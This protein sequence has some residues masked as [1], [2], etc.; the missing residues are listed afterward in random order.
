VVVTVASVSPHKVRFCAA[1]KR[2]G[3][4]KPAKGCRKC[5]VLAWRV[6]WRNPE[7]KTRSEVFDGAKMANPHD[8]A[9]AKKAELEKALRDG[10]YVDP[11][12]PRMLFVDFADMWAE[13][14]DWKDTTRDFWPSMRKRYERF[15]GKTATLGSIDR[16]RLLAIRKSL[17][18]VYASNTVASTMYQL[19]AILREAAATGRIPRDPTVNVK[20]TPKRR[21]DDKT[22]RV[23]PDK[24]PTADE[25]WSM[26][27]AAPIEWQ[28][29]HALGLAAL[30]IGEVL[31]MER[32]RV[33]L[34]TGEIMV[35][36]QASPT[37]GKGIVLTTP[38]AE[39][40]RT[41]IAPDRVLE[42]VAAHIAAGYGGA[43][44]D[45]DGVEHEMLFLRNG[46]LVRHEAFYKFGY[47]PALQAAG[48][49]GRF[50]F[51]GYRHHVTSQLLSEGA[52]MPAV[53]GYIGDHI[54][55]VTR[56]Y[57]HWL[58]DKK[59]VPARI[60]NRLY[61]QTERQVSQMPHAA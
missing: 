47:T 24:V 32:D 35:T 57:A 12:A 18:D 11:A 52:E 1:C 46:K 3:L 53:A 33:N 54:H 38:K 37:K 27:G 7:G 39:K 9:N 51:H 55:T 59:D 60:L 41:I 56:V 8:A 20:A 6:F 43:W 22:R 2:N 23:T 42:V 5:K 21:A 48:L 30:R 17:A 16:L 45:A 58:R 31:G 40:T 36:F 25:A 15:V 61:A 29:A 13:A 28:A 26:L 10:N 19:M 50:T 44:V 34:E 49:E 4:T 14:Q